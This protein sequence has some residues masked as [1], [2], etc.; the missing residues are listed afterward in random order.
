MILAMKTY[1]KVQLLKYSPKIYSLLFRVYQFAKRMT[2]KHVPPEI[3]Q[4]SS[5]NRKGF[6]PFK[7]DK[8]EFDIL[9]NPANGLVDAAIFVHGVMEPNFLRLISSNL[10]STDVFFD[11]GSNIGQHGLY[12]SRF[13]STVYCFEPITRLFEQLSL[14]IAKNNFT[15]IKALNLALG[16][17]NGVMPIFSDAYNMGASSILFNKNKSLEQMVSVRK[18]DDFIEQTPTR[19]DMM[20]IDVEGFEWEVLQGAEKTMRK[21]K[22]MLLIEYSL[23]W[24]NQIDSNHGK[25]IFDFLASIYSQ[26]YNVGVDHEIHQRVESFEDLPPI[27]HYTNLWCING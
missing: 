14:T 11:I 2:G 17:N 23:P 18:L 1:V 27:K 9:L 19:I 20:K 12:A 6:Y 25:K 15:N 5:F 10:K 21:Y 16:S 8:T 22:P 7:L 24:Y 13:C 4:L 3:I 26:I